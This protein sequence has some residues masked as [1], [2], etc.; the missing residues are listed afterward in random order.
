MESG[1]AQF[2]P[3]RA[4]HRMAGSRR[5]GSHLP[6]SRNNPR[7]ALELLGTRKDR[8]I[9]RHRPEESPL[10]KRGF[11]SN[12]RDRFFGIPKEIAEGIEFARLRVQI[13]RANPVHPMC[14]A[15]VIL[16]GQPD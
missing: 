2:Q 4:I 11:F 12:F 14:A 7:S 9:D 13:V 10:N 8:A 15:G 16:I 5:P 6:D 3:H 1:R